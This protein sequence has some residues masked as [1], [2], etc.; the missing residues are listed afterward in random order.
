M[1]TGMFSM[2]FTFLFYA[3]FIGG[4]LTFSRVLEIVLESGLVFA[5]A[6]EKAL[7]PV[8]LNSYVIEVSENF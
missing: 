4:N 3:V 8:E 5:L 1:V 2:S 7:E 6:A